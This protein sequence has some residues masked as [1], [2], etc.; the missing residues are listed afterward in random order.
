MGGETKLN[1]YFSK[2]EVEKVIETEE[3]YLQEIG[4]L[5][6]GEEGQKEISRRPIHSNWLKILKHR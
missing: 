1:H 3:T 6:K 4:L 2:A 5:K